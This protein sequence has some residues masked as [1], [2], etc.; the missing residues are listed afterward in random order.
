LGRASGKSG[1]IAA[2]SSSGTN[3]FA[4]LEAYHTIAMFC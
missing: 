1:S 2:H 4:I 3:G